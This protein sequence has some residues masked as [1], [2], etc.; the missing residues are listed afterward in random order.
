MNSPPDGYTLLFVSSA[1]AIVATLYDR[2]NFVFLRDIAPVGGVSRESF[3]MVVHPAVPATTVP[4]FITYAKANPGKINMASAGNGSL[5]HM[6]GE[7]FMTMAG[8]NMVHVPYRGS[9]MPDLLAGQ[10][11]V[12][13]SPISLALEYIRTGKLRGLAVTVAT[14]QSMVPD[15]PSIAEFVPGYEAGGWYG[16]GAPKN[17]STEITDR[18][19]K[20]ITAA[21]ADSEMKT[22]LA[23]LGAVPMPM[24]GD[25]FGKFIVAET[26][27][28]AKVVK[29]A[30][31]KVD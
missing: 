29:F 5:S 1:N 14:R 7:L 30:A 4:E 6:C 26:E 28:W 19:N 18:L 9:F 10:V 25:E 24:T 23:G 16:I 11:Q 15:L 21:L 20:E 27:K 3:V 12:V 17:T 13:F 31:I 22:Q 8:V 2:L